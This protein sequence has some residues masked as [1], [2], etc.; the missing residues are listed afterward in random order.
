MRYR[1]PIGSSAAKAASSSCCAWIF[2]SESAR[3]GGGCGGGGTGCGGG[4]NNGTVCQV[5]VSTYS[6][7]AQSVNMWV[8]IKLEDCI[9]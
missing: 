7:C 2:A 6:V 4:W 9:Y 8:H 5:L 3:G 1:F